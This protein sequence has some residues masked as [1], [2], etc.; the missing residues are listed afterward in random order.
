VIPSL[1]RGR[2]T[3][4]VA[5]VIAL[6]AVLAVV[7]MASTWASGL[8]PTG[9]R[10]PLPVTWWMI[11]A[12]SMAAEVLVFHVERR[13]QAHD[14]TLSEIPLVVGFFFAAPWVVVAGRLAGHF[15]YRAVVVRQEPLKLGFNM[16]SFWAETGVGLLC[17]R[18]LDHAQGPLDAAVWPTVIGAIITADVVNGAAVA[19]A[20]RWHGGDRGL[21]SVAAAGGLTAV[22]NGVMAV[23]TVVLLWVSPASVG[24]LFALVAVVALIYRHYVRLAQR[25]SGLQMLYDFTRSVGSSL[26]SESVTDEVLIQARKLLR[27]GV[28]EMVLIDEAGASA[29]R[30]VRNSDRDVDN[31]EELDD[32]RVLDLLGRQTV[33]LQVTRA[34]E[35]LLIPRGSKVTSHVTYLALTG[36]E[37]GMVAPLIV[38]GRVVGTIFVGDRES[39]VSTFDQQ[40]LRI[41]AALA[42]HASVAFENGRLVAEM[43]REANQRRHE[44]LHDPLTGLANRTLFLDKL[45]DA[46]HLAEAGRGACVMLMDLDRFK[47][48]NDTLGHHNGDQLLCEVA[49]R[50]QIAARG[51]ATVARLGGDEFALLLPGTAS[52]DDARATAE[53]IDHALEEPFQIEGLAVK[54]EASIGIAA[55]PEHGKDAAG[56]LQRA[57]V[58]MYQAK[59][60]GTRISIYA[61]EADHN[62]PRRL[63]LGVEL[64]HAISAG[65]VEVYYQPKARL[66]DGKIIG[67]E[68]LVRWNH[69]VEGMIGPDEFIP[70]AVQTGQIE[71]LTRLVLTRALEQCRAWRQAGHDMTVAV[72]LAVRC[73][74]DTGL[75][76]TVSAALAEAGVAP[77]HLTLEITESGVMADPP[78]T[79][80]V[81]NRL[82]ALGVRLS[83]DDFGTGYSSL[84]Y[85]RTLPVH[86]VKIDRSFVHRLAAGTNEAAI[87]QSVIDLGHHLGLTIVAEGVEDQL[88]WNLLLEQ[89]CDQVQGYLLSR[90]V[91]AE[92]LRA[93]LDARAP[94]T[95]PVAHAPRTVL[96]VDDDR[97]L[98]EAVRLVLGEVGHY[99]VH[100]A[101]DGREAISMADRHQPDLVLLDLSMPGMGGVE[102]LP[103]IRAASPASRIVVMS[104]SEQSSGV[105]DSAAARAVVG[106][107]DKAQ[108][109][110]SLPDRLEGLLES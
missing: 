50:L 93:W 107:L 48:V 49:Q 91:P 89:G 105:R 70:V 98:R 62:T 80:A 110:V 1:W 86:E 39:N 30:R 40:D 34:A 23:L 103:G 59:T 42:N 16:A 24:L 99:E 63:T 17:F 61:P 20:I 15:V 102:A 32:P 83:V 46:A 57:D 13:N 29:L 31:P 53:R 56:L 109:L 5:K 87:V 9:V 106:Y 2:R 54:V 3:T 101:R 43:R 92:R 35:P 68:A 7:G 41:F 14:F 8:L 33:W 36:A 19:L 79:I 90:P 104:A 64:H 52:A 6:T 65:E 97:V 94:V 51:D 74:V 55:C 47:E 108:D 12:G 96:I 27:A 38:D 18:A 69:P 21:G 71:A 26:K 4:P 85:L 84:S 73:L 11:A 95:R 60:G 44:A 88:S 77:Q 72:N 37:D 81:L 22:L 76:E 82:A 25:Y 58:A 78:R 67:A 75:P 100:E 45:R 66:V 28:A 10:A